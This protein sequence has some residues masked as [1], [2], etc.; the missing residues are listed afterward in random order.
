MTSSCMLTQTTHTHARV[1]ARKKTNKKTTPNRNNLHLPGITY[2]PAK[3]FVGNMAKLSFKHANSPHR[4]LR[5]RFWQVGHIWPGFVHED[6][7][8]LPSNGTPRDDQPRGPGI[9]LNLYSH[10]KWSNHSRYV[11]QWCQRTRQW[12]HRTMLHCLTQR[13]YDERWFDQIPLD[14]TIMSYWNR[15]MKAPFPPLPPPPLSPRDTLQHR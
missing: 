13:K 5:V 1:R 8:H 15:S 10:N 4:A 11:G 2:A 12:C 6:P 7:V 9:G 14:D 3:P